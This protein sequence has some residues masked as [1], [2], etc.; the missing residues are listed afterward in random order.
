MAFTIGDTVEWTSQAAGSTTTVAAVIPA[1]ARLF[2]YLTGLQKAY[3]RGMGYGTNRDHESY[4]VH[5][6]PTTGK[7]N[8]K[9]YWPRVAKL[10]MVDA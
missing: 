5:V 7:G 10:K 4:V 3:F 2:D 8:G 6:R 9:P 1:N